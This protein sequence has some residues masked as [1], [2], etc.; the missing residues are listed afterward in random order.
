M[1]V[2]ITDGRNSFRMWRAA[3]NVS[4]KICSSPQNKFNFVFCSLWR[5]V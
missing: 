4:N 1:A 3:V 5:H 2:Q